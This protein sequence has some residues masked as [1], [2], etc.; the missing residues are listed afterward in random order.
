MTLGGASIG[1]FLGV[2]RQSE[3]TTAPGFVGK[4]NAKSRRGA[5]DAKIGWCHS[6]GSVLHILS[7]SVSPW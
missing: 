4:S 3:A 2:R 7:V 6:F 5:E 1:F